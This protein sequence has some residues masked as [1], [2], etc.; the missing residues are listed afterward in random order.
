M[1]PGL[2]FHD[3]L[4]DDGVEDIRLLGTV[5][6]AVK[7][8]HYREGMEGDT[9]RSLTTGWKDLAS[10]MLLYVTYQHIAGTPEL[11]VPLL[12]TAIVPER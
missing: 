9:Y 2:A 10:G 11:Y 5:H 12:P 8:S 7:I 4:R 6:R 1:A 3:I